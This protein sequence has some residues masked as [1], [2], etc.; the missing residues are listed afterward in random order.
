MDKQEALRG[1]GDQALKAML[2]V[3][4]P[5][6]EYAKF[7]N[8][9][10]EERDYTL[11]DLTVNALTA[12][13]DLYFRARSSLDGFKPSDDD[14]CIDQAGALREMNNL[15]V[16]ACAMLTRSCGSF[17]GNDDDWDAEVVDLNIAACV[18]LFALQAVVYSKLVELGF[19]EPLD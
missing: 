11:L 7:N 12:L 16:V 5:A 17:M 14:D 18:A 2:N 6:Y 1:I 13:N 3:V 4:E 9:S 10:D 8:E 19:V 15:A